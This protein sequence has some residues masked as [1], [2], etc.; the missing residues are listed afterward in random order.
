MD[1]WPNWQVPAAFQLAASGFTGTVLSPRPVLTRA[2]P[3][4]AWRPFGWQDRHIRCVDLVVFFRPLGPLQVMR[5]Y[6]EHAA[7]PQRPAVVVGTD[8][9][10]RAAER[11]REAAPW[12][13]VHPTLAVTLSAALA[14]LAGDPVAALR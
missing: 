3:Y 11:L 14:H 1:S 5:T 2:D 12:L 6:E 13:T 4:G 9:Q 10:G 8:E 7:D